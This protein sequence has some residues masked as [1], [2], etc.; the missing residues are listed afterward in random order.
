MAALLLDE[1]PSAGYI[2]LIKALKDAFGLSLREA[3]PVVD[4][5]TGDPEQARHSDLLSKPVS[6]TPAARPPGGASPSKPPGC[7]RIALAGRA[8][9]SAKAWSG[10]AHPPGESKMPRISS[11]RSPERWRRC[12]SSTRV[13]LPSAMKRTSTSPALTAH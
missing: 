1:L 12:S 13:E 3:K 11:A 7:T 10:L 4:G 9:R 5:L 8:T 2:Q 6:A